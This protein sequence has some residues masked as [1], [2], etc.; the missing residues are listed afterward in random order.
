MA[1]GACEDARVESGYPRRRCRRSDLFWGERGVL[2]TG[3]A[4]GVSVQRTE[5]GGLRRLRVRALG[6]SVWNPD[7]QGLRGS[8]G[9][10]TLAIWLRSEGAEVGSEW[11]DKRKLGVDKS[12]K[13]QNGRCE[14]AEV[15]GG[16]VFRLGGTCAYDCIRERLHVW[17][18]SL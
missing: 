1:G 17:A 16:R 14:G 9:E 13:A 5:C 18:R 12:E 3:G 10:E 2:G 6:G 15:R 8:T 11:G 4:V 7:T